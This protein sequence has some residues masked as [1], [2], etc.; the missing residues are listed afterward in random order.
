MSKAIPRFSE[1]LI[2]LPPTYRRGEKG[3]LADPPKPQLEK[4]VLDVLKPHKPSVV[5]LGRALSELEA[6]RSVNI[7]LSEVDVDTETVKI[8]VEGNGLNYEEIKK[9]IKRFGAAIHSI[10]EVVYA[11]S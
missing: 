7:T 1:R 8:V 2:F 3:E 9:V 4:L 5:E 6:V 11:I 10:D